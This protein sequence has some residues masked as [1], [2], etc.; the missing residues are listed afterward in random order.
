M[1]DVCP[2][3][4]EGLVMDFASLIGPAVVAA[5]VSGFI[6]IVGMIVSNRTARAIHP[7]K[8]GFDRD[9]AD[10]KISADIALA[11]KKLAVD[12]TFAAWKRRTELA[13]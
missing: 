8:L 10:R 9:Q 4:N 3:A 12:R 7:E 11:E 2:A 6:S 1:G 13:E 5:C